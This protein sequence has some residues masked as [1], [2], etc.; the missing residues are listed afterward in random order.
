MM[1]Q[2][3]TIADDRWA[4]VRRKAV[5]YL[6]S[7]HVLIEGELVEKLAD[8]AEL[9]HI[10]AQFNASSF[11]NPH[12][13]RLA[14][15]ASTTTKKEDAAVEEG[16]VSVI[17]S[18][19][20]HEKKREP[21]DF[22]A[23]FTS[24][25]ASLRKLLEN[26]QE[27]QNAVSIGRILG[28][29]EKA[30]AAIIGIVAEKNLTKNNNYV[31]TLED[32]SGQIKVLVTK[33]K[34]DVYKL[35][36]ELVL[37]EVIGVV[38][39]TQDTAIFANNI[40]HPD[41]PLTKEL[42]KAPDDCYVLFLSDIHVGSRYFLHDEFNRFLSWIQG[43]AGSEEQQDIAR[44]VKYIFFVGDLVDGVGIY[45]AQERELVIKDIYDQYTE[46]TRLVSSIPKHIKLIMCAGNHDALRLSEPQ[47]RHDRDFSK[48]L[49]GLPNV[50]IVSNPALVN[51]HAKEGFPGIDVLMYH[52]YSFDYYVANVDYIREQGG[53]DRADLIMKFLLQ[54]RHLAPTHTS[55]LYIPN[56]T[57]DPLIIDKVPDIFASGHI[58]K[59]VAAN[60]RNVTLISGSCWQSTTAFQEKM[61][62]RPE[63]ARVPAVNLKTRQVKMLRF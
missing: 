56:P 27:L 49:Y 63:P 45:P 25:H 44:K 59:A 32:P 24:R 53:Y 40:L 22:V 20:E 55:T 57:K 46:F 7:K 10:E 6:L 58:H 21:Q 11:S 33:A 61:G 38:G 2:L 30:Q 23:Y 43:E 51:I 3:Q 54:R 41:V 39:T 62:H 48:P 60:Y 5:Q 19:E 17:F 4:N 31:I 52:G 16:T 8:P 18:Y 1:N 35:A 37:D 15:I 9:E 26:R 50:T 47:P 28:K 13:D 14:G 36:S 34:A 29:K 12:L 42:K